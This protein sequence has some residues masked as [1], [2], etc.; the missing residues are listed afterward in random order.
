V[1]VDIVPNGS[2]ITFD[3]THFFRILLRG[4][5]LTVVRV[6]AT[7]ALLA[8]EDKAIDRLEGILPIVADWHARMTPMLVSVVT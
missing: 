6:H 8:T 7:Q 1:G 5:Q 2:E 4:N 3:D